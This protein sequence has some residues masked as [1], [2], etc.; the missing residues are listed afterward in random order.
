[1]AGRGGH[2]GR[3]AMRQHHCKK[4]KGLTLIELLIGITALSA[5]VLI[6]LTGYQ[7]FQM[8]Y[9]VQEHV[10]DIM[11][12]VI[13]IDQSFMQLEGSY[14]SVSTPLVVGAFIPPKHMIRAGA[15]Y[16][17]WGGAVS[18]APASVAS[19]NDAFT[20]ST[21]NLPETACIRLSERLVSIFRGR[22]EINGTPVPPAATVVT[23][24][25][26][27]QSAGNNTIQITYQ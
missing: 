11:E 9:N 18:F 3:T 22:I 10:Q 6:V 7:R 12:L 5:M 13:G 23:I 8:R 17:P 20:I 19:A 21:T 14:A 1:M 15:V 26:E 25:T 16:N 4:Q 27:C 2:S 24:A